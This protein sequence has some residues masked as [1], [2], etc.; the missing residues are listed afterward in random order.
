[1]CAGVCICI[2]AYVY[3][4]V[5]VYLCDNIYACARVARMRV[6]TCVGVYVYICNINIRKYVTIYTNIIYLK[7]YICNKKYIYI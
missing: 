4:V 5:C 6:C 7:A 3:M 1:M 2:Y